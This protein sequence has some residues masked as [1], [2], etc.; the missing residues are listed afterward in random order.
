MKENNLAIPDEIINR[1]RKSVNEND[2]VRTRCLQNHQLYSEKI[3]IGKQVATIIEN[4]EIIYES[5][6]GKD[7]ESFDTY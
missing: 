2:D 1:K 3:E 5:L 4:G 7:K 6:G